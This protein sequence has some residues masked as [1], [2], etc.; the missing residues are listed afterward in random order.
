MHTNIL[1]QLDDVAYDSLSFWYTILSKMTLMKKMMMEVVLWYEQCNDSIHIP[2][3]RMNNQL[4][5]ID[6][7]DTDVDLVILPFE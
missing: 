6:I 4:W 2:I 3:Q 1:N 5:T 7:N